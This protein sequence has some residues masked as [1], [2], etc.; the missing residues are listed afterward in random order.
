MK[1]RGLKGG[2][3]DAGLSLFGYNVMQVTSGTYT[4]MPSAEHR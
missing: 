3:L 2:Q 1:Y 4:A